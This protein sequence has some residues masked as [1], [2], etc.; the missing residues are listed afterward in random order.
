[1]LGIK[2]TFRGKKAFL[3]KTRRVPRKIKQ[4]A[5]PRGIRRIVKG[6]I[7]LALKNLS[8]PRRGLKTVTAKSGRQRA[9]PQ[10]PELAG[11]YPVPRVSG[12]LLKLLG[13]L[14]PGQSKTSN[15]YS[16]AAGP[17]EG[18]LFNSAE[19]SK[20]I[21][22]GLG[23]SADYGP[24]RFAADAFEAFNAGGKAADIMTEEIM[25]EAR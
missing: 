7:A 6:V 9:V 25:K 2:T 12:N 4:K 23:S 17:M 19:Y 15:G 13:W 3:R 18:L 11:G 24:R 14:Y 5:I 16:F 21:S 10:K 20:I 8:G 22:E 1:M